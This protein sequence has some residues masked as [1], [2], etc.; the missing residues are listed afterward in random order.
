MHKMPPTV[1]IS[2]LRNEQ[3]DILQMMD[4]Q[5]VMLTQRG[6]ARAA[7]VNI[8]QWNHIMDLLEMYRAYW[9]AESERVQN[10][11][12][13]QEWLDADPMIEKWSAKHGIGANVSVPVE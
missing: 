6:K 10:D 4:E 9:R 7:L 3:D 8:E 13:E 12:A 5:P 11:M 2:N 1:P